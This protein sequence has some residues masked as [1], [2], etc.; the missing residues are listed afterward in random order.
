MDNYPT[1]KNKR[2]IETS[3][4]FIKGRLVPEQAKHPREGGHA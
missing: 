4:I 3:L 2:S 1:H